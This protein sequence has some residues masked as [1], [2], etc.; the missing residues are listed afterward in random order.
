VGGRDGQP[1]RPA[2]CLPRPGGGS[3]SPLRRVCDHAI[4][5][6]ELLRLRSRPAGRTQSTASFTPPTTGGSGESLGPGWARAAPCCQGRGCGPTT[7]ELRVRGYKRA[8]L[9]IRAP[10]AASPLGRIAG[11]SRFHPQPGRPPAARRAGGAI[12]GGTLL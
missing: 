1:P 11:T 4:R 3:G 10:G 9:A 2:R 5:N 8:P 12:R 7:P 6:G